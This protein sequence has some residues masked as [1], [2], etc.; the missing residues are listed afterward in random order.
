MENLDGFCRSQDFGGVSRTY[1]YFKSKI[2]QV[3]AGFQK[4]QQY[5]VGLWRDFADLS[6]IRGVRIQQVLA[7]F[8]RIIDF[9]KS[10]SRVLQVLGGFSGTLGSQQ[11]LAG[12]QRC[13]QNLV[14]F[15]RIQQVLTGLQ[16]AQLDYADHRRMRF[17]QALVVL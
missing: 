17:Q 5:L 12:F 15:G 9:C 2:Q 13:Q 1:Q 14:G 8:S 7:G 16:R 4:S 6:R 10:Q 3:L 11:I